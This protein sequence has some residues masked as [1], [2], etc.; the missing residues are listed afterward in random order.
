MS[1]RIKV[2][3]SKRQMVNTI[4]TEEEIFQVTLILEKKF[5][6]HLLSHQ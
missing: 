2:L 1:W 6:N 3:F 5:N 4:I